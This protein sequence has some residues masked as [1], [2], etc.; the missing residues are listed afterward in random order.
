MY[1]MDDL[2]DRQREIPAFIREHNALTRVRRIR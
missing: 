1:A 2:T